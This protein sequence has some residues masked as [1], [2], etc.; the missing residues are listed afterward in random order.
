M[1]QV[2]V[3]HESDSDHKNEY[4][5][6]ILPTRGKTIGVDWGYGDEGRT[7]DEIAQH[8]AESARLALVRESK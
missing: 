2:L 5:A 1:E 6:Y 8:I 4:T 3:R 7:V